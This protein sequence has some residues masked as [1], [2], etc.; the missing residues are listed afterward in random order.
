MRPVVMLFVGTRGIRIADMCN[1]LISLTD[2][3]I[4]T[5]D[6][7]L[8]RRP[9]VLEEAGPTCDVVRARSSDHLL[10]EA[11]RYAQ[12]TPVDG[13]LTFSDDL[14]G[15]TASFAARLG[16]PGQPPETIPL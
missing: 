3:V 5:S 4:A 11:V 14:I 15:T 13:A 1:P 2:V 10:A 7:I 8:D 6:E 9:D 16:L 12:T